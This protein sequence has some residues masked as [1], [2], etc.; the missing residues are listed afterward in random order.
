MGFLKNMG[1][2][3]LQ[4]HWQGWR[5]GNQKSLLVSV[6]IPLQLGSGGQAAT[7][8]IANQ[9]PPPPTRPLLM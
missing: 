3:C 4:R 9:P 5:S 2:R 7:S 1:F 8:T 6:K